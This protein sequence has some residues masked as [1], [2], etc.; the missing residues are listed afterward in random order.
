MKKLI[1]FCFVALV[2]LF[3]YLRTVGV[4]VAPVSRERP[5]AV[6]S[7]DRAESS[8]GVLSNEVQAGLV[9]NNQAHANPVPNPNV[10]AAGLSNYSDAVA[11]AILA[12][13]KETEAANILTEADESKKNGRY[14]DGAEKL[15]EILPLSAD[16]TAATLIRAS[17]ALDSLLV[18]WQTSTASTRMETSESGG[19]SEYREEYKAWREECEATR[20]GIAN[21][22]RDRSSKERELHAFDLAQQQYKSLGANNTRLNMHKQI[23]EIDTQLKVLKAKQEQLEDNKPRQISSRASTRRSSSS[24]SSPSPWKYYEKLQTD[25]REAVKEAKQRETKQRDSKRR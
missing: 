14:Q 25:F 1:G 23:L 8:F 20:R 9:L 10:Q 6:E 5:S 12:G 18:K 13:A 4:P 7:S 11:S 24:T 17:Q 22:E 3:V 15:R 16:L 21:F 19:D 2:F